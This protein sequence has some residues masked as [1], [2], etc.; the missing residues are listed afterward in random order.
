[1]EDS[2]QRPSRS[3][4]VPGDAIWPHQRPGCLLGAHEGCAAG[5]AEPLPLHLL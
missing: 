2:V 3:F 4:G 1:M 5:H